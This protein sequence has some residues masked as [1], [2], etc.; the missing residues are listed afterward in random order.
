MLVP[1]INSDSSITKNTELTGREKFAIFEKIK[2]STRLKV[3]NLAQLKTRQK[4]SNLAH[5]GQKVSNPTRIECGELVGRGAAPRPRIPDTQSSTRLLR[6]S[7]PSET[8][9]PKKARRPL[10][11]VQGSKTIDKVRSMVRSTVRL[12]TDNG[13]MWKHRNGAV[14][15]KYG[16][17]VEDRTC[18]V[19]K[20]SICTKY[21]REVPRLVHPTDDAAQPRR[22]CLPKYPKPRRDKGMKY[23]GGNPT[24]YTKLTTINTGGI[25]LTHTRVWVWVIA[26][27]MLLHTATAQLKSEPRCFLA[28]NSRRGWWTARDHN[29][30][31]FTAKKP[32]TVSTIRSNTAE[33]GAHRSEAAAYT[34]TNKQATH[35]GHPIT[36][37]FGLAHIRGRSPMT[38]GHEPPT[39]AL[40]VLVKHRVTTRTHPGHSCHQTHHGNLTEC[41]VLQVPYN[42]T[43]HLGP[44]TEPPPS[45][46]GQGLKI[47]SKNTTKGKSNVKLPPR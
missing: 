8:T 43:E 34:L 33:R 20:V 12:G 40:S 35:R 44:L 45:G 41:R 24:E 22:E 23:R 28:V 2:G 15:P 30:Q 14:S 18:T 39:S 1:K 36:V 3:S 26:L 31:T 5:Y 13:K 32:H 27:F 21:K 9:G 11:H 25:S 47:Q 19:S 29:H 42:S 7:N 10:G 17:Q 4:V 6:G 38:L 46:S 16:G 37:A